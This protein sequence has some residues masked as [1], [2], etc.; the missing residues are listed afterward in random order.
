MERGKSAYLEQRKRDLSS[1]LI[2]LEPHKPNYDQMVVRGSSMNRHNQATQTALSK[3]ASVAGSESREDSKM[4]IVCL[5]Y[6][7]K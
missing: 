6:F 1:I 7:K 5:F 4:T 3:S 2:E